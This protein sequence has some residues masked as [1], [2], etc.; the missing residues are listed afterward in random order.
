MCVVWTSNFQNRTRRQNRSPSPHTC[1]RWDDGDNSNT[2][3]QLYATV[4]AVHWRSALQ[5]RAPLM[6]RLGA[7]HLGDLFRTSACSD[8]KAP[9]PGARPEGVFFASASSD[10]LKNSFLSGGLG[11][12]NILCSTEI[13]DGAGADSAC[14]VTHPSPR[15]MSPTPS[16]AH[17][18]STMLTCTLLPPIPSLPVSTHPRSVWHSIS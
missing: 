13:E 18:V 5:G 14:K 2:I 6:L 8:V 15:H 7:Q 16:L 9:P 12:A 4:Q 1:H 10:A 3:V 11:G 17:V